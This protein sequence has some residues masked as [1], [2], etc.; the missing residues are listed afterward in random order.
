MAGDRR[1]QVADKWTKKDVL[2]HARQL[3]SPFENVKSAPTSID[4]IKEAASR[5][6][7]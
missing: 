6:R 4:R 1:C 2:E 3:K 7:K 5:L